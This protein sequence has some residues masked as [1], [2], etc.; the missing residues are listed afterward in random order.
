MSEMMNE[1]L[2]KRHKAEKVRAF[3]KTGCLSEGVFRED[4]SH[5]PVPRPQSYHTYCQVCNEMYVDFEQH[6]A[7]ESHKTRAKNQAHISDIDDVIA[8]LNNS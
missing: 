2:E 6:V 5:I 1:E 8:Q 3:V 7:Q 4:L